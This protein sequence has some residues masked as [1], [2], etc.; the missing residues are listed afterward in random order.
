MVVKPDIPAPTPVRPNG[1][2]SKQI[3][4]AYDPSL[5]FVLE[6]A[7]VLTSRD[8][9]SIAECGKELAV[10]LQSVVSDSAHVHP[11]TLSRTVFYLLRFLRASHDHDFVRAPVV[12]HTVSKFSDE[13][14]RASAVSI[15]SGLKLC[16][17]GPAPLRNE[18]VNSPDFW[19]V[20]EPLQNTLETA[21]AVFELLEDIVAGDRLSLTADNYDAVASLLNAFGMSAGS[22]AR[23]HRQREIDAHRNR[24]QR[25][26]AEGVQEAVA[27]GTRAMTIVATMTDR[28][29]AFVS[30]SQLEPRRAWMRYWS[31]PLRTLQT[32]ASN[33]V[34]GIRAQALSSLQRVL[35]SPSLFSLPSSGGDDAGNHSKAAAINAPWL[36]THAL[37]PLLLHLLK[38]EVWHADPGGMGETRL[39]ASLLTCKVYLRFLDVLFA[40]SM[41]SSRSKQQQHREAENGAAPAS[42]T[43]PSVA[44]P[45]RSDGRA[46][47]PAPA[48]ADEKENPQ[49]A[50]VPIFL[51]T[52]ELL[53]RLVKS[54][55][56]AQQPKQ[57][58]KGDT[59]ADALE[60]AIPESLKNVVLVLSAAGYLVRPEELQARAEDDEE[61]KGEEMEHV[62]AWK[63]ALW[64]GVEMRLERFVP[65]LLKDILPPAPAAEQQSMQ[66][67]KMEQVS[68]DNREELDNPMRNTGPPIDR[69]GD[70]T[71]VPT[72]QEV[73]G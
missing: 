49:P 29:P 23:A 26:K 27:R 63:K 73:Q 66:N 14:L 40:S 47:S 4:L 64:E 58:A 33:P 51:R 44:S 24:Q 19:L 22:A 2:K 13:Q 7:T 41:S 20:L 55:A 36:F 6:L 59:G 60:E 72:E 34:R 17:G 54:T 30:Q 67:E 71:P 65:G 37:F 3:G 25:P 61:T 8:A 48:Y 31:R 45:S 38:P 9:A 42:P 62:L 10:A 16:L 68:T 21:Q 5:V 39:S 28:V 15:V 56:S 70:G 46:K 12:L 53:E 35:L 52:L 57:S 11:V 50:A 69:R 18:I 43:S 1:T 32:H